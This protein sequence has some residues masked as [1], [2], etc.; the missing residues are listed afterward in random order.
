MRGVMWPRVKAYAI[1]CDEP[2]FHIR[3][4]QLAS[5]RGSSGGSFGALILNF[6]MSYSAAIEQLNTMVPELTHPASHGANSHWK[7]CGCSCVRWAIHSGVSGGADCGNQR[8]G[9]TAS[10][11]ASILTEAG[12]RTGLYTSPH[13][14]RP[15]ERIRWTGRRLPTTIL[16]GSSSVSAIRRRT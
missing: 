15:N 2:F 16:P 13:L 12:L 5:T 14:E 3:M 7:R 4:Y 9:S 8:K 6:R 11:L 1:D 10:T